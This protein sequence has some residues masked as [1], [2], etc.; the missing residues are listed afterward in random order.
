MFRCL[1]II[2]SSAAITPGNINI[3]STTLHNVPLDKVIHILDT[4]P[5][6]NNPIVNVTRINIVPDVNIV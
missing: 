2:L 5:S 6:A 3:I 1:T 4:T